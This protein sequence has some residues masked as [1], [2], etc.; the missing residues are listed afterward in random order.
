MSVLLE[1]LVVLRRVYGKVP[2]RACY[3]ILV[4]LE[5]LHEVAS[6]P[7]VRILQFGVGRLTDVTVQSSR[8]Q[9]ESPEIPVRSETKWANDSL[10]DVLLKRLA[11]FTAES[12]FSTLPYMVESQLHQAYAERA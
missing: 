6:G 3:L 5:V 11:Q 2:E 10:R 4:A 7:M 9:C 8:K 12:W 1:D